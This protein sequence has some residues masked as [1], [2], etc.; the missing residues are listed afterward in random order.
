MCE[1]PPLSRLTSHSL[2][3]HPVDPPPE[4]TA[5]LAS[6][7]LFYFMEPFIFRGIRATKMPFDMMPAQADYDRSTT[8]E[9]R[10]RDLMDPIR[11]AQ[12]G[13]K[14]RHLFFGIMEFHGTIL[15]LQVAVVVILVVATFLG[16]IAVNRLLRYL[17]TGG[18]DAL[19]Q[20]W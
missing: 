17:E 10:S 19:V 13:L 14:S 12:L 2:S 20:P 11:R 7:N 8:L 5:S 18:K 16:P 3:Q 9:A 6:L 1:S 15:L 4:Q